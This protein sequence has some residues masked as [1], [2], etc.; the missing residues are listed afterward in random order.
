MDARGNQSSIH[1]TQWMA[2]QID[3]RMGG[4][5][6]AEDLAIRQGFITRLLDTD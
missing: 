3:A 6:Q 4:T 2:E 5:L 1:V